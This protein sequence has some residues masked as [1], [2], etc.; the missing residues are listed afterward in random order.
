MTTSPRSLGLIVAGAAA[1]VAS[2]VW[3]W[4]N[5]RAGAWTADKAA[6]LQS[7]QA[8]LHRLGGHGEELARPSG[9]ATEDAAALTSSSEYRDALSTHQRLRAELNDAQG[10]NGR[11]ARFLLWGGALLVIVGWLTASSRP[12]G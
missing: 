3:S 6:Q 11:I 4:L 1:I 10:S 7:A 8:T 5:P 12:R 2:L 9:R